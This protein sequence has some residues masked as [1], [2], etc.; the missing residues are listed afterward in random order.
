MADNK[1]YYT[2]AQKKA[3]YKYNEKLDRLYITTSKGRKQVYTSEADRRGQS[4]NEFV[5]SCVE[6]EIQASQETDNAAGPDEDQ[7]H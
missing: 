5:V 6:K 7:L 2:D 3:I 1:S 4:L